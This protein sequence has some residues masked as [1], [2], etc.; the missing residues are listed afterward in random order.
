[1]GLV[2]PASFRRAA[3]Y[4]D[5]IFRSTNPP[6]LPIEVPTTFEFA[7]NLKTAKALG[8]TI[9]PVLLAIPDEVIDVRLQVLWESSELFRD[10]GSGS[11][12]FEIRQLS[13]DVAIVAV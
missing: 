13:T 4:V 9:P 12:G 2:T 1:M 3:A 5:K 10:G 11:F 8:V 6:I 7:I